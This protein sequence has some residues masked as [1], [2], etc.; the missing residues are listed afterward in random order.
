[1]TVSD[2]TVSLARKRVVGR[3][4]R[5]VII[6]PIRSSVSAVTMRE[7]RAPIAAGMNMAMSSAASFMLIT[8]RRV[9]SGPETL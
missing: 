5:A 8:A 7:A 6:W 1:M 2:R 3:W 4:P 9:S